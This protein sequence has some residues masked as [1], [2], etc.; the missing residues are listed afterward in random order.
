MSKKINWTNSAWRFPKT[1]T[2]TYKQFE[3]W[4]QKQNISIGISWYFFPSQHTTFAQEL[5]VV[6]KLRQNPALRA[7][8]RWEFW[9]ECCWSPN[10]EPKRTHQWQLQL[11]LKI[12]D[13]GFDQ[14]LM[15]WYGKLCHFWSQTNQVSLKKCHWNPTSWAPYPQ[16][17]MGSMLSCMFSPQCKAQNSHEINWHHGR[18]SLQRPETHFL[19][20]IFVYSKKPSSECNPWRLPQSNPTLPV[21]ST[22]Q[23][24]ES[25]CGLAAAFLMLGKVAGGGFRFTSVQYVF[26]HRNH[27]V[28]N[29]FYQ[30]SWKKHQTTSPM[31]D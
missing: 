25:S 10:L 29:F 12:W 4:S 27:T 9:R 19:F 22:N 1:R 7:P 26:L 18:K 23:R 24:L 17:I 3:K 31:N 21:F 15:T 28:H 5:K 6:Q 16:R 14:F 2:N 30:K 11:P 8:R 13:H 20:K